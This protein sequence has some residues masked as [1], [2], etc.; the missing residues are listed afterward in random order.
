MRAESLLAFAI[1][2]MKQANAFYGVTHLLVA[3]R[4]Q[5]LLQS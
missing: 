4:A 3:R 1:L 2:A 5:D